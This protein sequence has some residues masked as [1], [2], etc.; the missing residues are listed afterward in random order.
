MLVVLVRHLAVSVQSG[1][2][3]GRLDL[4]LRPNV[5][6]H[7]PPLAAEICAHGIPRVWT[8]PAVRCRVLADAIVALAGTSPI[9][10]SRLQELHFGAWEGVSWD[11]VPRSELDRWA[12][13]PLSIAPPGGESGQKFLDRVYEIH[14]AICTTGKD[15]VVVSHGGPLKVLSALLQGETPDLCAPAPPLGSVTVIATR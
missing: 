3:Y 1:T 6:E 12:A 10:D 13:T 15:C 2:C 9:I 5:L 11:L 8:S 7:V 4:S 14:Q